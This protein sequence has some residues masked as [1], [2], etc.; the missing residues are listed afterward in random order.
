MRILMDLQLVGCKCYAFCFK[1]INRQTEHKLFA[2]E[3]INPTKHVQIVTRR[4]YR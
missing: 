4:L 1:N 2:L 3:R